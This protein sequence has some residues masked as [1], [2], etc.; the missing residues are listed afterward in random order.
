MRDVAGEPLETTP[1]ELVEEVGLRPAGWSRLIE[2]YPSAGMTD[3]VL[4]LYLATDLAPAA[5]RPARTRRR[6]TW[7]CSTCRSDEAVDMVR[8]AARSTTP[9]RSSGCCS[10]IGAGVKAACVGS[11][12][13]ALGA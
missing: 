7:R 12:M 3:S 11:M 8:R 4:H 13:S 6:S 2:F 9:R 10:S 1:A 5:S